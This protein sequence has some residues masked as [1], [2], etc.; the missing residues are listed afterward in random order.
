MRRQPRVRLASALVALAV[1]SAAS[2]ETR[3][4]ERGAWIVDHVAGPD[5][6]A[7]SCRMGS[8]ADQSFMFIW[9]DAS[10]VTLQVGNTAWDAEARV[11]PI[12]IEITGVN[13]RFP[14]DAYVDGGLLMVQGMTAEFLSAVSAG[15]TIA[16][17]NQAGTE[18]L[19]YSLRGS[20]AATEALLDCRAKLGRPPDLFGVGNAPS[21][22]DPF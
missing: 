15:H 10:G 19:R 13:V 5:G 11:V 7:D 12:Q 9:A 4:V 16:I 22:T 17:V 14:A 18:L 20:H 8:V 3:H 6:A 2:A 21:T 1:A